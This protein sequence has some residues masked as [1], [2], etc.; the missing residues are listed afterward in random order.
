MVLKRF[1]GVFSTSFLL[2]LLCLTSCSREQ[3]IVRSEAEDIAAITA[4]S[5]AR[6]DAFNQGNAA[7]IAIHFAEDALLMAP[8]KPALK[9]KAGVQNYYQDIFDEHQ[10]ALKSH[11]EEV[12]VS[13]DLAYGRGHAEVALTSRTSQQ[14]RKSSAKYI[15]IMK[16]QA[17]GRWITTHDIW[18]GNEPPT[19]P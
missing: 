16:R 18:N 14:V 19:A 9:G 4:V 1:P 11:Y 3:R 6:A 12:K 10:T 5:K 17:D 15:N 7:A 2:G 8:D 13:G